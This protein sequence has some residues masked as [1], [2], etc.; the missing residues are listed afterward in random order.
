MLRKERMKKILPFCIFIII[1]LIII[2]VIV[3]KHDTKD[4]KDD[5]YK[6]YNSLEIVSQY[7]DYVLAIDNK[8][9]ETQTYAVYKNDKYQRFSKILSLKYNGITLEDNLVFWHNDNV[10]FFCNNYAEKYDLKNGKLVASISMYELNNKHTG[11]FIKVL[12]SNTDK[13][14]Y[15]YMYQ[16]MYYYGSV[17]F[18]LKNVSFITENEIDNL[19]LEKGKTA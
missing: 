1:L 2:F 14:Y 3:I 15:E 12:G 4:E 13:I 17:D 16:S 8:Y 7:K 10:Y 5:N 19:Q 9:S 6:N 11:T 18:T